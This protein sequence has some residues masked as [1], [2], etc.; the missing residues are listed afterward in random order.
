M[1][2]FDKTSKVL[3][4][5]DVKVDK[6][7]G[8]LYVNSQG[9]IEVKDNINQNIVN[10]W[11]GYSDSI[12]KLNITRYINGRKNIK[13]LV[14]GMYED[15]RRDSYTGYDLIYDRELYN[16]WGGQY[17]RPTFGLPSAFNTNILNKGNIYFNDLIDTSMFKRDSKEYTNIKNTICNRNDVTASRTANLNFC[18]LVNIYIPFNGDHQEKYSIHYN[19]SLSQDQQTIL[20]GKRLNNSVNL[21][22]RDLPYIHYMNGNDDILNVAL[23]I[24]SGNF[25]INIGSFNL[26]DGLFF[27]FEK[28]K[29][30]SRDEGRGEIRENLVITGLS[31]IQD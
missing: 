19:K 24:E 8:Y 7:D 3:K 4:N 13:L 29:W 16:E 6:L 9:E 25:L 28:D 14:Y 1:S 23:N 5:L 26:R 22:T 20:T 21:Y 10:V 18:E 31:I 30:L 2:N 12:R 11:N 27:D 15:A 17:Y